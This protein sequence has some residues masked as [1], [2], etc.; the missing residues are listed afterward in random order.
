M[1]AESCGE[2]STYDWVGGALSLHSVPGELCLLLFFFSQQASLAR[3]NSSHCCWVISRGSPWKR[4]SGRLL[5]AT[6]KELVVVTAC[7]TR[8]CKGPALTVGSAE[9]EGGCSLHCAVSPRLPWL[10]KDPQSP[11]PPANLFFLQ[12]LLNR[13]LE[14]SGVLQ[15]RT[16]YFEPLF[17][18]GSLP[19][20]GLDNSQNPF[21]S[22][23]IPS[24]PLAKV[25]V[26]AG[27]KLRSRKV[28]TSFI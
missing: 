7:P 27:G 19:Y 25:L 23:T 17:L 11:A 21:I 1:G 28:L 10:P 4:G 6:D 12:P 8:G 16:L 2:S 20:R 26:L 13:L 15:P 22:L 14:A 5:S 9:A 3:K 24:P 18:S